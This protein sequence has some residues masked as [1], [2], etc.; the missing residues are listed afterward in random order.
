MLQFSEEIVDMKLNIKKILLTPL[1]LVFSGFTGC[2]SSQQSTGQDVSKVEFATHENSKEFGDYVIHVNA[3]TT[4]QL[5]ADVARNYKIVRSKN[6]AMLNVVISKKTNG[7][8]KPVTGSVNTVTR[9]L[10]NQLKDMKMRE[11]IEQDAIYYIGDIT[12][13]NEE[14]IVF[15]INVTPVNET[16]PFSMTYKQQFFTQ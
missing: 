13:D 4:D 11:I 5:P 14:T 15:D 16:K 3:L 6:R 2:D 7:A 12:V 1:L 10:A 8:E 9:N